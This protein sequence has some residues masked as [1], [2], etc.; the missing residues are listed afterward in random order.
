VS[1]R[2]SF[3]PETFVPRHAKPVRENVREPT[4]ECAHVAVNS[5]R[6]A[7]RFAQS[8]AFRRHPAF[9]PPPRTDNP[10]VGFAKPDL[11]AWMLQ[12]CAA[13]KKR[14]AAPTGARKL[15]GR[16]TRSRIHTKIWPPEGFLAQPDTGM[17]RRR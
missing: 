2:C 17:R 9:P 5:R 13:D 1:W 15:T 12:F 10:R 4:L 3:V 8:T 7:G 11:Y 6:I 16:E 14:I